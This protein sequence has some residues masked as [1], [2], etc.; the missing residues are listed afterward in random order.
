MFSSTDYDKLQQI[1]E[2]SPQKRE[3][4]TRLLD[5]HQMTLSSISH[6]IRNP[7][8]LVYSTLQL[9]ASQHPEV[10]GFKHWEQLMQDVEYIKLLLEELS[11]YNNS[12][13]LNIASIESNTFFKTISLSFA[14]SVCD[15]EIEFVSKIAPK[16]P[17]IQ[18]DPV[19]LR[20]VLLNLLG[21]A[22]DAV[23]LRDFSS[24]EKSSLEESSSEDSHPKISMAVSP[25]YKLSGKSDIATHI[26]VEISDN[27]CGILPEHLDH[28]FEPFATYKPNG[29]GLGLAIA[30]RIAIAH[31]GSLTVSSQPGR[32]AFTLTLPIQQHRT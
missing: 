24:S 20:Q 23:M 22:R 21:N 2:E 8:T 9:I 7:L 26:V 5:S 1:M 17:D 6:E 16:L 31:N 19:K 3:L 30:N 18:C 25:S 15:T 11:S 4:L 27:G 29:T 13:K 28:I 14:S 10:T 32:T 12:D